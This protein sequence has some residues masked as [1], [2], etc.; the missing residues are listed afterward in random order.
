MTVGI[1]PNKVCKHLDS[2][3]KGGFSMEKSKHKYKGLGVGLA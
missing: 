1:T 2:W 3:G